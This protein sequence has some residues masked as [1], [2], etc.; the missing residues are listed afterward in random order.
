MRIRYTGPRRIRVIGPYR[1]DEESNFVQ[2]V[3]EPELVEE[4]L[5]DPFNTFEEAGEE[6]PAKT[7][8]KWW[9]EPQAALAPSE[10]EISSEED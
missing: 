3:Q 2:D 4:L 1:W 6:K 7:K 10:S 5:T 8:K 9:N